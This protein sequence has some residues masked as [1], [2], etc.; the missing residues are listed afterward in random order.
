ML[1]LYAKSIE[2]FA[3]VLELDSKRN[4]FYSFGYK[5]FGGQGVVDEFCGVWSEIREMF[6]KSN[7]RNLASFPEHGLVWSFDSSLFK[8]QSQKPVY[9]NG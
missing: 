7:V 2:A 3:T 5:I 1:W 9:D 6:L 8:L 4:Y